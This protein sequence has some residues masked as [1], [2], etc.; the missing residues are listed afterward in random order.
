MSLFVKGMFI[1]GCG[2]M[3]SQFQHQFGA[4]P[5]LG[6]ILCAACFMRPRNLF[7]IGLGGMLVRDLALGLSMFTIVRLIAIALVALLVIALKVRP[8][9]RSVLTGLLVVSPVFYLTLAL[10]DWA[11]GTCTAEP[12]TLAGL[13]ASL[14]SAGPYF[15]RCFAGDTL[16]TG[17]FMGAYTLAACTFLVVKPRTA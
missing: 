16:F 1:V 3:S 14:Q 4:T 15:Q 11:T 17:L 10:G 12:R 13:V 2:L 5:I 9:F 8:N 7:L 6:A